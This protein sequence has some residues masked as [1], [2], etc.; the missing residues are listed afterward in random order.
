MRGLVMV[1]TRCVWIMNNWERRSL[2][3]LLM[4]FTWPEVVGCCNA[5]FLVHRPI[6][7]VAFLIRQY[8][9]GATLIM[10]F[11]SIAFENFLACAKLLRNYLELASALVFA[12]GFEN[13]LAHDLA[14]EERTSDQ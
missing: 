3:A 10:V 4:F 2:V 5:F 7:L 12:A 8:C 1:F 9:T 13:H 14:N 11:S 6:A